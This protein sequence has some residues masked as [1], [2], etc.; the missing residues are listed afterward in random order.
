M[1]LNFLSKH[2][3]VQCNSISG[4]MFLQILV[5]KKHSLIQNLILSQIDH[6][7][8]IRAWPLHAEVLRRLLQ[9]I[10]AAGLV[11]RRRHGESDRR[12]RR[13]RWNTLRQFIGQSAKESVGKLLLCHLLTAWF[14]W[15]RIFCW[16]QI[17]SC[18]IVLALSTFQFMPTKVRVRPHVRTNLQTGSFAIRLILRLRSE[19]RRYS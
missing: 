17:E 1:P 12:R 5:M 2:F 3:L 11:V 9:W 15:S 10:A 6:T 18:R 14:V 7:L 13:C 4:T 16:H 19:K 8:C